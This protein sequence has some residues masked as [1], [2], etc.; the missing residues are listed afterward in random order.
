MIYD[1]GAIT[2][3]DQLGQGA[4]GSVFSGNNGRNVMPK[5]LFLVLFHYACMLFHCSLENSN[6]DLWG[7]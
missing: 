6:Q 1:A 7:S 3:G 4:F 5:I 2:T